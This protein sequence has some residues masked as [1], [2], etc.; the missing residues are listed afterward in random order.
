[1]TI[2]APPN[3]QHLGQPVNDNIQEASNN[4]AKAGGKHQKQRLRNGVFVNHGK[5]DG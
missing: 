3:L 2:P 1:M 5:R 4:Q